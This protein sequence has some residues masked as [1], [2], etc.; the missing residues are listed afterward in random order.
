MTKK[1]GEQIDQIAV[2]IA[3]KDIPHRDNLNTVLDSKGGLSGMVNPLSIGF[4]NCGEGENVCNC[5][6]ESECG[7]VAYGVEWEKEMMKMP[8]KFIID[9][10]RNKQVEVDNLRNKLYTR[11]ERIVPPPSRD[12]PNI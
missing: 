12:E 2:K 3:N 7:Y 11:W 1:K 9:M 8:K 5:K 10:V 6:N 4:I